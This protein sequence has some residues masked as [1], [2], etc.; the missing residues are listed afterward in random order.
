M[1]A[2]LKPCPW[3]GSPADRYDGPNR[4]LEYIGCD[5]CGKTFP[6]TID[7]WNTRPLEDALQQRVAQLEADNAREQELI[8]ARD[9]TIRAQLRKIVELHGVLASF[10]IRKNGDFWESRTVETGGDHN[11]ED[12][13][14][15]ANKEI[16]RLRTAISNTRDLLRTGAP[17]DSWGYPKKE[18]LDYKI[19]RAE[20][21]L[22]RA[23]EAAK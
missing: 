11:L 20:G 5:S 14:A 6:M 10:G 21:E 23:L 18:W 1:S 2:E 22:T 8:Q 3:C 17:P 19:N 13:L 9:E 15:A 4:L 16:E 12:D 7:V